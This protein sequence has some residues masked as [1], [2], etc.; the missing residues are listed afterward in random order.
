M[1]NL[2]VVIASGRTFPVKDDL[3]SWDFNW[4]K[5]RQLWIAVGVDEATCALFRH[6]VSS[7]EWDEVEL[8]F[9]KI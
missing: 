1:K 6:K 5:D 4:D 2:F 3:K 9:K 8:E 7:G